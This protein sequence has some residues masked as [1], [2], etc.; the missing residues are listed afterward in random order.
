MLRQFLKK[1]VIEKLSKSEPATKFG[2]QSG[3]KKTGFERFQW[4]ISLPFYN[5]GQKKNKKSSHILGIF[6]ASRLVA[7]IAIE[8]KSFWVKK[9]TDRKRC[10]S[11]FCTNLYRFCG[12][13]WKKTL[14]T[15]KFCLQIDFFSIPKRISK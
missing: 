12:K 5:S 1:L 7:K 13:C 11:G 9:N 2:H 6:V 10:E 3:L 14:Q 8:R 4:A 15:R